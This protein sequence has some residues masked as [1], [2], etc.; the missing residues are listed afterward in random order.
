M[1]SKVATLHA[2][3]LAD[4]NQS[5]RIAVL[6]GAILADVPVGTHLGVFWL[7]GRS[8]PVG[9]SSVARRLPALADGDSPPTRPRSGAALA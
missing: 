1:E 8:S 3:R 5:L 4:V 6:L 7:C 2:R 9:S